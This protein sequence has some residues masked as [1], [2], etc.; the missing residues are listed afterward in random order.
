[1]TYDPGMDSTIP[2]VPKK[3]KIEE[4]NGEDG[5]QEAGATSDVEKKKKKKKR[6]MTEEAEEATVKEEVV[7]KEEVEEPEETGEL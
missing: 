1:M 3:R 7:V 5:D 2:S 6:K 4:V